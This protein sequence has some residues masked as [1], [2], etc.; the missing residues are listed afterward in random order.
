[1]RAPLGVRS[2]SE[3]TI[4]SHEQAPCQPTEERIGPVRAY[5]VAEGVSFVSLVFHHCRTMHHKP[6]QASL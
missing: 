6:N 3:Q 4:L 1:M 5:R 2:V